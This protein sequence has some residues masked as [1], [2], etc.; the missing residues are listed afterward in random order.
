VVIGTVV[1][2]HGVRGE[3][4]VAPETDFP[5]RLAHLGR[6]TL[7]LPDG[8]LREVTVTGGRWHSAKGAVLLRFAEFASRT[9]AE[10]LRGARIVVRPGDS[11]MLPEGEYY[12]WQILGLRVVT[13][14]GREL[15]TVREVI[16]T[17]ANDVY[18]TEDHLLPAIA[19]VVREIDLAGR[20]LTIAPLP[21]LLGTANDER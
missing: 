15:G 14:D 5:E 19:E 11:P 12:D 3:V 13:T 20:R 21:G 4:R 17:P 8:K 2:P 1:A 18:A 16:H 10:T 7:A 6:A 9:E